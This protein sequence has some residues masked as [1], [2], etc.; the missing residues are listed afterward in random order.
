[1]PTHYALVGSWHYRPSPRGYAVFRYRAE[2]AGLTL[3]ERGF[4]EASVGAQTLDCE[5]RI[6]Y[7]CDERGNR[8]GEIGG[9]GYV[10]AVRVEPETGKLCLINEQASLST[11][12]ASICLDATGKYA[13]VVH[14][15]DTGYATGITRSA[16]GRYASG[17]RFDDAAVVLLP[18]REGGGLGEACDV[19][20][21]RGEGVPGIHAQSRLHSIV[22]DPTGELFLVCDKGMDRICAFGLDRKAGKL[23]YKGEHPVKDGYRPRYGAFHPVLPVYYHNN[24]QA[25]VLCA[26]RYEAATGRLKRLAE[27]PL[28]CMQ[29][30]GGVQ[31]EAADIIMHSSGRW[32]YVSD[33]AANVIAAFALDEAG[34][35][36]LCQNIHCGGENPRGLCLSPDARFLLAANSDTD[37]IAIFSVGEDGMLNLVRADI[38]T[39][40]PAN[41]RIM[42]V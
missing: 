17:A 33:R 34:V 41:I 26:Y 25:A 10:L 11:E 23:V 39:P 21:L 6:A 28:L 42:T 40:C 9:G 16:D 14:H 8:R 15:C 18:L 38:H 13:L 20:I 3:V 37:N 4:E 1:M 22:P 24:E 30:D 32:L 36:T 7:L 19:H 31:A 27:A 2:D 29:K 12:P 35:P 5:N